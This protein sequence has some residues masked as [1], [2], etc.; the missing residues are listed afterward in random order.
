MVFN[1]VGYKVVLG[2][3]QQH[4]NAKMVEKLDSQV[5]DRASLTEVKIPVHLAYP[6]ND[7]EFQRYDGSVE[8]DGVTYNFVERKLQNDTLILHCITNTLADNIKKAGN[9]YNKSMND[10]QPGQKGPKDTGSNLLLKVLECA[11]YRF[12]HY[13]APDNVFYASQRASYKSASE[14]IISDN[15]SQSP[16]QPPD[17]A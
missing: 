8:I 6:M 12:S 5:Y 2:Y 7:K 4:A 3:L 11:G 10:F 15:F 16:E 14:T 13:T 1:L 17:M 9:D